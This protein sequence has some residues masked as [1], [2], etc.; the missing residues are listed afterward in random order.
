MKKF[1][2]HLYNFTGEMQGYKDI[3]YNMPNAVFHIAEKVKD[4]G[5][6]HNKVLGIEQYQKIREIV[7][8]NLDKNS[9]TFDI[10]T[11]VDAPKEMYYIQCDIIEIENSV[12]YKYISQIG[13]D[14]YVRVNNL[15]H[16]TNMIHMLMNAYL[17]NECDTYDIFI[18]KADREHIKFCLENAIR[19]RQKFILLKFPSDWLSFTFY[20]KF[21]YCENESNVI[22]DIAECSIL[23][24]AYHSRGLKMTIGEEYGE[25]YE[26]Q[27]T[28]E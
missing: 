12:C 23:A 14:E 1:I 15:K 11:I 22:Y 24:P 20:C 3:D 8:S 17:A 25:Y 9:I 18:D 10:S 5:N 27:K 4:W 19:K 21:T 7:E 13:E 26:F 2:T 16:A 6:M 28:V